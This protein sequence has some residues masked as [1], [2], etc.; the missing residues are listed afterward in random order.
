MERI[1]LDTI[2][3]E[4]IQGHTSKGDQPKW[5]L[6]G[7]WYKA[8]HMGYESLAEVVVSQLL[9]QSN[10]SD[11]VEY[12]PVWLQYKGKDLPGCV[13]KNF[14]A[15]DEMLVPF[16]KLHRAY[17][18]QGLAAA[19]GGISE[20]RERI[21]YTVDFIERTTGLTG[22][23]EYLTLLLELDSFFLNEDRHTNNLAVIRNEKTMEFRLCPIFDHGLALLSDLNDYPVD[24]DVYD[25]MSHVRAK[26]FD[27]DFDVQVEAAEALYGSQLKLSFSRTDVSKTLDSVRMLYS[28]SVIS[29]VEQTLYEQMRR[30]PV[31]F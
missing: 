29:R 28:N 16:E 10:V 12:E 15:K 14:R 31:Y 3:Q 13:S 11:F 30:Y 25:C 1:K 19:L 7:K 21:R 18:G 17:K 23:G 4:P 26:P 5:Q 22:V 8:D 24:R 20:P 2:E 27:V 6:K 9:K